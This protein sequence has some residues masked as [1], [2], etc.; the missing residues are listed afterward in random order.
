MKNWKDISAMQA[1]EL[2]GQ[3]PCSQ[4]AHDQNVLAWDKST[5]RRAQGWKGEN[6]ARSKGQAIQP[7]LASLLYFEIQGV[8][9][10][11]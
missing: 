2:G 9:L 10:A 1:R 4:T 7:S 6:G 3:L 8:A 5:S 11:A